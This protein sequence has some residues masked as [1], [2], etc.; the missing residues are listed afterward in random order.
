MAAGNEGDRKRPGEEQCIN[1]HNIYGLGDSRRV[2]QH[3]D[4]D[5]VPPF[6]DLTRCNVV[7][8][9]VLLHNLGLSLGFSTF[10]LRFADYYN[11]L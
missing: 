5:A 9:S 4:H 3:A 8:D 7:S 2:L 6:P 1:E 11:V 10:N